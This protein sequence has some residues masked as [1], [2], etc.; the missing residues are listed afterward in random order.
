MTMQTSEARTIRNM[1]ADGNRP[2]GRTAK[3]VDPSTAIRLS[4]RNRFRP[5]EWRW[6]FAC[7]GGWYVLDAV[8][9]TCRGQV[10]PVRCPD[11][12]L[13]QT[14]ELEPAEALR[15]YVEVQLSLVTYNTA[16]GWLEL[17]VDRLASDVR[18]GR[19]QTRRS[20]GRA[21]R[22]LRRRHFSVPTRGRKPVPMIRKPGSDGSAGNP[23]DIEFVAQQERIHGMGNP[24]WS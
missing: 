20:I 24:K 11:R 17:H 14:I 19:R 23:G 18:G 2:A 13:Q 1:N 6:Q 22:T 15:K 9:A 5:P 12:A 16:L 8:L 21:I 3:K 10:K 7:S 4:Q